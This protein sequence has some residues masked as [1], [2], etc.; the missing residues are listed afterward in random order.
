MATARAPRR[1]A[2]LRTIPGGRASQAETGAL[3]ELFQT[4]LTQARS[5]KKRHKGEI[6]PVEFPG[7]LAKICDLYAAGKS[8]LKEIDFKVDF[9]AQKLRE[10]ALKNFVRLFASIKKKPPS[11]DYIG[12]HSRLKFVQTHRTTLT[13][14]K[15]NQLRSMGIPI[16]E[17]TELTGIDINMNEIRRHGLT[18]KLRDGLAEMGV[19]KAVLDECFTPKHELNPSFYDNLYTIVR[20]SLA[21]DEDLEGKMLEVVNT[22]SPAEQLRNV[23]VKDMDVQKCFDLV[24]KTELE[25]DESEVA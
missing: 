15:T 25:V 9:A 11:I 18:D 10:Y 14:E 8:V 13:L 22:L 12:R 16:D 3:D 7:E 24:L 2:P 23:E 20:D 17:Y 5:K 19:S 1:K 4:T 21:K 6:P